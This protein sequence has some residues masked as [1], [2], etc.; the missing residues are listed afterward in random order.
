MKKLVVASL[1]LAISGC[2]AKR[3]DDSS[4][5]TWMVKDLPALVACS[6]EAETF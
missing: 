2:N 3:R 6:S 4:S 1:L 5:Y